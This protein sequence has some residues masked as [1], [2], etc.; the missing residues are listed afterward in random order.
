[1]FLHEELEG[2]YEVELSGCFIINAESKYF[3]YVQCSLKLFI[4]SGTEI[5]NNFNRIEGFVYR[6]EQ[7]T[8]F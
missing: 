6:M 7:F 5:T 4:K 2:S 8:R 1:M 3:L